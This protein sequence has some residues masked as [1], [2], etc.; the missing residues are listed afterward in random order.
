MQNNIAKIFS[1]FC[2]R[3]YEHVCQ[4]LPF[5]N[6]ILL[7]NHIWS[8]FYWYGLT[9]ILTWLSKDITSKVWDELTDPSRWISDLIPN[10]IIDSITYPCWD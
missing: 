3:E 9:L 7:H 8:F 10:F 1:P 6:E 4:E 5:S 2:W